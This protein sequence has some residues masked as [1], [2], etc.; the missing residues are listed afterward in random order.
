MNKYIQGV[1]LNVYNLC[2]NKLTKALS[3]CVNKFK[4]YVKKRDIKVV[5]KAK[6]ST[7]AWIN[8]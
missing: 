2:N 3:Y 8:V 7:F 6:N 1:S 4:K 5:F